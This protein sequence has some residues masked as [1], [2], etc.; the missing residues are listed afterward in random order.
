VT[1]GWVPT[2]ADSIDS[3]IAEVR[4]TGPASTYPELSGTCMAQ[5]GQATSKKS[6]LKSPRTA[7][8]VELPV[9]GEQSAKAPDVVGRPRPETPVRDEVILMAGT[10]RL[11]CAPGDVPVGRWRFLVSCPQLASFSMASKMSASVSCCQAGR[12]A[13]SAT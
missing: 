3:L 2:T 7:L 9:D 11:A 5:C 6:S 12:S 1:G 4:P 10:T 8:P 13:H